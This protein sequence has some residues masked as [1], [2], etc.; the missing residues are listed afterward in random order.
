MIADM[1]PYPVMKD[2]GVAWLG[3]VPKHWDITP[4]ARIGYF[5]KGHGGSK[6]DEVEEGVPCI[7]YGDLYTQHEFFIRRTKACV[8]PERASDYTSIQHSDVLFAASG[9]T[10]E[11]IGKS[12]VNL[13]DSEVVC[14]GDVLVFR[15]ELKVV[16]EFLGFVTDSN[17]SRNQ[18]ALM[19]R[20]FTIIHIYALKL[21]RLVLPLPP[22][23]EQSAIVNFLNYIDRRIQRYIRA[24]KK[25][26][27]LLEEY[28]Q[29]IIN[30]AVTKGLNPDVR[31][32]STGIDWLEKIPEHWD[33]VRS[34]RLFLVRGELARPGDIQL[35]ATQTYGVIP[36][37]E[38]EEKVGRKV[39]KVFLHLEK[40]RHVERDDFVISM[41]SF[42]GGVERAWTSGCIRSSYVIMKP[43]SRV[44][45]GFFSYLLKSHDYIQALRATANFIR[46]G[47]DMNFNNFCLVDLPVIPLEEQRTIS[48]ILKQ[49]TERVSNAK[50]QARKE[51]NLLDEY[52]IRLI[53]DVVTGKVDVREIAAQLPEEQKEEYT[54]F[55]DDSSGF[56]P[57]LVGKKDNEE[58]GIE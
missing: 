37:A 36:Q 42:Q 25:L 1:K 49:V 22:V 6:N 5:F 50:D 56:D 35:S 12:A 52:R 21:K 7:R 43:V 41:R 31:M 26:I 20:G 48:S 29:A 44:D 8:T 51:I 24:K 47:Q 32:K 55:E 45:A 27:S 9:E 16:P 2:S 15:P 10:I 3:E 53:S 17:V 54:I 28:K 33:V 13:I 18:K 11:D 46:D 57:L 23:L 19:G 40:R 30:Q 38:F 39:T 58:E 34:K 4:L 14:G